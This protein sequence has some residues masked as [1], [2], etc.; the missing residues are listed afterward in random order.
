MATKQDGWG[1]VNSELTAVELYGGACDTFKSN[2]A[3]RVVMEF[4]CEQVLVG[5]D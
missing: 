1:W 3:T 2:R 4:G 5:P